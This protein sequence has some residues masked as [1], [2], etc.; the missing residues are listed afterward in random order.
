MIL[1][2]RVSRTIPVQ[3]LLLLFLSL[4]SSGCGGNSGSP[5]PGAGTRPPP[6]GTITGKVTYKGAPV[7]GGSIS[8]HPAKGEVFRTALMPDGTYSLGSIPTGAIKVSVE[9]ETTKDLIPGGRATV[10]PPFAKDLKYVLIPKK[11]TDPETSGL[12]CTINAGQQ[13]QDFDLTD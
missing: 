4:L 8:F 3:A 9:T 12:T 11:Y 10:K 6:V 7:S 13:T 1:F 2:R 5:N